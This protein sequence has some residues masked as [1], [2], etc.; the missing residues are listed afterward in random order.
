MDSIRRFTYPSSDGRTA[1]A[2]YELCPA[3]PARA[4]IQISHGMCE[5]FLRYTE[6]AQFLA[7]EGFLVFGHDHLGHGHSAA[8]PDDLGFTASGGGAGFLVED[9]H[10]LSLLYRE[11]H[12]DL[13]L[14]LF[15]HSMGSFI[16]RATLA[17]YGKDYDAA[18]LCGTAGPETPA[19]AGKLLASLLMLFCGERHRSPLLKRISFAGYNKRFEKGC[20]PNAWLARDGEVLA[21]YA[22]D[23]FCNYTFTLRAYHDLF[24]LLSSVSHKDWAAKLPKDLPL[25]VTGG[26]EDPV[27]GWGQGMRTVYE[28]IRKEGLPVELRLYPGLRHEIH[29]EPEKRTVWKELSAWMAKFAR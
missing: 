23:P 11:K 5:Y 20:D 9:L 8:T 18:V 2:A 1:L 4:M 21:R 29:N 25:L 17:R 16:A 13:P 28:R 26:E 19:A 14:V 10:S 22:A 27:G 3:T 6:F 12:P 24:T 7:S 15:G